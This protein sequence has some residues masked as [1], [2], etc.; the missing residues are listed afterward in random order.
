VKNKG[1]KDKIGTKPDKNEKRGEAEKSEEQSQ[2]IKQEKL[3]KMK[4]EGPKMQI[5]TKLLKKKERKK[6]T[7]IANLSKLQRQGFFLPM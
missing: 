4:V 6:G 3:K 2:S 1:E 5:P 7:E